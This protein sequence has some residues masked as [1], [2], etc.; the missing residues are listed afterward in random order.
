MA[1]A[2]II[3]KSA[4]PPHDNALLYFTL[5][6]LQPAERKPA[7]HFLNS[8]ALLL[9]DLCFKPECR[10]FALLRLNAV[11]KAVGFEYLLTNGKSK[12]CAYHVTLYLCVTIVSVKY[13]RQKFL[14]NALSVV[15]YSIRT[16]SA[17]FICL[18]RM[19]LLS[20]V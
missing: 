20:P 13:L 11:C 8:L 16:T 19:T 17:L 7:L 4:L 15:C 9:C 2:D 1:D 12:S 5:F 6:L 10:A 18:I 14:G 3:K